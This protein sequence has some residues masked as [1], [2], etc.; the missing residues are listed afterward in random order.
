MIDATSI[1]SRVDE[2]DEHLNSD[3]FFDTT[4]FPEITFKS[5]SIKAT[6]NDNYDVTGDLTIKGITR[7]LTLAMTVNKAANHPMRG[8]PM[9]GI[10]GEATL[11]RSDFDLGLYAPN[12]GDDVN[13]QVTAEMV[14]S[15]D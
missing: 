13:I 6:G 5:T 3:D 4:K 10:S 12:V 14:K 8:T 15:D 9:I 11:D 1:N 2:F 7:P